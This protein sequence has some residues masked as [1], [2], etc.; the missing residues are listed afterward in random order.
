MATE[1]LEEIGIPKD[2]GIP[3]LAPLLQGTLANLQAKGLP[4]ALT[5]PV[6]RGDTAVV[7]A[8]QEALAHMDKERQELYRL[9]STQLLKETLRKGTLS[10]EQRQGLQDILDR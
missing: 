10:E 9:L 8:H 1:L 7:A 2:Q 4:D 5:G 3:I 6:V